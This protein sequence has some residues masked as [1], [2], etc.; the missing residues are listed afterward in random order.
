MTVES[1][2]APERRLAPRLAAIW[3]RE[4]LI[5]ALLI[6][7]AA[8]VRVWLS[9]AARVVWGDEP[10]YLWLGRNWLTGQG[11]SFT[12][13][14]D[15]HHAPL[16]PLLTGLFYLLTHD[17]ALSSRLCYILFGA[18]L[19]LP[20]YAI[21]RE[22]YDRR[23]GVIALLLLAFYPALTASVLYWG[24]LTEPPYYFFIYTGLYA[25]LLALRQ[26]WAPWSYLAAGMC[27]ALAYLTRPEAIAHLLIIGVVLAFIPLLERRLFTRRALVGLA[28]YGLGF[29]LFFFPYAYYTFQHTGSWMVSEKAGVTFITCI[30]LSSGDTAAFDLATWG[31]DGTGLEVFFFSRESYNVSMLDYILAFPA[32]FA[33]LVYR[34]VITFFTSLV[35]LRLFPF[36]LLPFVTL[37]LWREAWSKERAKGELLLLASLLPVA[38]FLIFFIQDR[39]IATLLPTLILWL[40]VGLRDV[41]DWLA[42]TWRNLRQRGLAPWWRATLLALPVAAALVI[43]L[44]LLP[45]TL[46]NV[47]SSGSFR[48]AHRT[49][50]EWLGKGL[51]APETV[52]MSRYPA[53]AFHAGAKWVPTPNAEW[54]DI[55]PYARHK[56]VD[57]FIVD[58]R[59]TTEL[60]PQLDF[61][62]RLE[63]LPP[64]LEVLRVDESEP[65]RLVVFR[66]KE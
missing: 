58:E 2:T 29:A 43:C 56:G 55:L 24:T 60:R 27:F 35:S 59:E 61:L 53:L 40:A 34:N 66:V 47:T 4:W 12:G 21:A 54:Q 46:A 11:Y 19:G 48:Q 57:L 41:G 26:K 44:A 15:V 38:G 7:L 17:M 51:A 6:L 13:Y 20:I 16:Y 64:E 25:A 23:A 8:A 62:V 18:A 52:I 36:F 1:T 31:L 63:N 10:F 32:E 45:R 14:S 28:L 39:Y 3:H 49:V 65:E 37:A 30:G 42:E 9:S 50:G 22:L 33:Q 5:V